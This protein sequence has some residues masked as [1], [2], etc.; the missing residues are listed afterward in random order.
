MAKE[1]SMADSSITHRVAILEGLLDQ[2]TETDLALL[3][4]NL[5]QLK[6]RVGVL[7]RRADA[8]V[9]LHNKRV[10]NVKELGHT[11]VDE[12]HD[13]IVDTV[14]KAVADHKIQ[15]GDSSFWNQAQRLD[16]VEDKLN[17]IFDR[18]HLV[19]NAA[20]TISLSSHS[21][22]E[23]S[24]EVS[25]EDRHLQ[26]MSD[27]V[28]R[29][30]VLSETTQLTN[31]A[32]QADVVAL[33]TE[34]QRLACVDLHAI[35]MQSEDNKRQLK[36]VFEQSKTALKN[37][38]QARFH[39]DLRLERFFKEK[40]AELNKTL[41]ELTPVEISPWAR[42]VNDIL[43]NDVHIVPEERP[44]EKVISSIPTSPEGSIVPPED[45]HTS[46]SL[47]ASISTEPGAP[48]V[49]S[50]RMGNPT[51]MV[52]ELRDT[53]LT[54]FRSEFQEQVSQALKTLTPTSSPRH[55]GGPAVSSH[56]VLPN[57]ARHVYTPRVSHQ[58]TPNQMPRE[59][60][61]SRGSLSAYATPMRMR[62]GGSLEVLPA[63]RPC[64]TDQVSATVSSLPKA[65]PLQGVPRTSDIARSA[66]AKAQAAGPARSGS[67]LQVAATPETAATPRDVLLV[68]TPRD[69]ALAAFESKRAMFETGS[70][71]KKEVRRTSS[72]I[73]AVSAR[74]TVQLSNGVV[75]HGSSVSSP[76]LSPHGSPLSVSPHG[77]PPS[78]F[79]PAFV[80]SPGRVSLPASFS[81]KPPQRGSTNQPSSIPGSLQLQAL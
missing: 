31:A 29:I 71:L 13:H 48:R 58:A 77:S 5:S 76:C 59:L 21:L 75:R 20:E 30:G 69:A 3:Q 53:I 10:D 46:S 52:D 64:R 26:Q 74:T 66:D 43:S 57:S 47:L 37:E 24:K 4:D 54:Y 45:N 72:P 44:T 1:Q 50:E 70:V 19:Q 73:G 25:K 7:E 51:R 61:G 12:F 42:R 36:D 23:V 34:L 2:L 65:R 49:D 28:A 39:E 68:A 60:L 79:A 16:T 80:T 40:L 32:L 81:P 55:G 22:E 17:Q 14:G 11:L 15:L 63:E 41:R 78:V 56:S 35:H 62:R 9:E 18:I 6:E 8:E 67:S 33:R 38:I 27:T